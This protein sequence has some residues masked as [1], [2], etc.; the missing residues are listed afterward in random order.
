[1]NPKPP[2]LVLG[3]TEEEAEAR[4]QRG[5]GNLSSSQ[6]SRTYGDIISE[7]LFNFFN[8]VLFFLCF[9][10][11]ILGHVTDALVA[12]STVLINVLIS[13]VQEINAKRKLEKIAILNRP[14]ATV[15][16][17][18]RERTIPPQEIVTGDIVVLTPGDQILVDGPVVGE[19]PVEVDESILTGESDPVT[20]QPGDMLFSGTFCVSGRT[21]YQAEKVGS[22][23]LANSL[24]AS[25]RK[26]SRHYTEL[27]NEINLIVRVIMLIAFYFAFLFTIN[28]VI[29]QV[30]FP[31]MI[32]MA[33]VIVTL[34][35][36][37]LFLSISL[38]Y[39]LGAVRI[40]GKGILVQQ[41]NAVESISH[42]DVLCIDKTGT[43]TTNRLRYDSL[44][45]LGTSDEKA[46]KKMIA[47]FAWS[48]S[49]PNATTTAITEAFA[50]E[51]QSVA[52]DVPFAS[53]HKW[54]AL[55][56][57]ENKND[58]I[59]LGAPDILLTQSSQSGLILKK[60]KVLT[61]RGLRV[62]LL[63]RGSVRDGFDLGGK[64]L[65]RTIEPLVLLALRDE[66]R[67]GVAE[68][69]SEFK[70]AQ[71]ELK[72][73]SGDHPDTV[74]R[75]A[76]QAGFPD[77]VT[78][79]SGPELTQ[80]NPVQ[81]QHA[82]EGTT[83]FGRITPVQ[84]EEIIKALQSR[85]QRVGMLGDGVNDVLALKQSDL[86]IAMKQGSQA[87]RAVSDI[88]LLNNS[89]SALP[90]AVREGQ[91]INNGMQQILKIFIT[92]TFFVSLIIL[93]T[94]MIAGFPFSPRH[95]SL[96]GLLIG[97]IPSFAL[98][99]WARPGKVPR[100]SLVAQL[101]RFVV[102]AGL[103][104]SLMGLAVYLLFL[105]TSSS[106]MLKIFTS[107]QTRT[108]QQALLHAQTA[109]TIFIIFCG[110]FLIPFLSP[111]SAW[112]AAGR[113]ENRDK[114]P[115]LLAWLIFAA[116]TWILI[117]PDLARTFDLAPLGV[118]NTVFLFLLSIL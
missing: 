83:I 31:E 56:Y 46:G 32:K 45:P 40:L 101:I 65:P 51:K 39:A 112:W 76:R 2:A 7:N 100:H 21:V 22:A 59:I 77:K 37:G 86:A 33:V 93:S 90:F 44:L 49:S 30:P 36:N 18:A 85:G 89:F 73:I 35:P 68:T 72:V 95:L 113:E 118:I 52:T 15:I 87:A 62:L 94:G 42:L 79:I 111:P 98:V 5:E 14:Q 24:V 71:V 10:L 19:N 11:I 70:S 50:G 16:R 102:P 23:S 25:A 4:K 41:A 20:K 57:S 26:F 106:L 1:M 78:S 17:D 61:D 58:V 6:V 107:M 99:L 80:M 48:T 12:V 108:A 9:I 74:S 38:S 27:Q 67:T 92:R 13:F 114:K 81:F 91:R 53:R 96:A 109:V 117:D 75:I 63:G 54:S 47:D 29:K 55:V 104:L 8:Q 64:L 34:V 88:T 69:L 116:F 28:S 110:I 84:K 60:M 105:S 43:L 115:I 97:G 103:T 82:V 3:L 66:L